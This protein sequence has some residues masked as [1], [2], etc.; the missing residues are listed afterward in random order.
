M[1]SLSRVGLLIV[2]AIIQ[3]LAPAI[4][5]PPDQPITV[6]PKV[7][8]GPLEPRVQQAP[9]QLRGDANHALG[10]RLI[11]LQNLSAKAA[12]TMIA[13]DPV[14]PTKIGFGRDVPS[15]K[16]QQDTTTQ[17]DWKPTAGGMIGSLAINSNG[18][19][20]LR[21]GI[22]IQSIPD[23]AEVRFFSDNATEVQLVSG[24][25]IMDLIKQN[26][27][28]S[29]PEEA[30]RVY[31]SP[32]IQGEI[33]GVEVFIPD[34]VKPDEVQIS[35]PQVSHLTVSPQSGVLHPK[36]IGSS[37]S[38]EQDAICSSVWT[39]TSNAVAQMV[40]MNNGSPYIC[41]G[42]LLN[43][44]A[45]DGIPYFLT[46]NHCISTQSI[47]STLQTYWFWYSTACNSGVL[48]P[49]NQTI[50]VGA[51]L[52]YSTNVTDTSFLRLSS[53]P[54]L[55]VSYAGWSATTPSIGNSVTGLHNPQGDLRKISLGSLSSFFTCIDSGVNSFNCSATDAVS[56]NYL[57]VL[58]TLGITEGGSSGSSVFDASSK[59]VIGQ[60][61]G[62]TLN[63]TNPTGYAAYGRFDKAYSNGNLGQWLNVQ[64]TSYS[65]NISPNG[66]DFGNVN[67]GSTST[68]TVSIINNSSGTVTF[69]SGYPKIINFNSPSQFSIKSSSCGASLSAGASCSVT[70]AFSPVVS[71][72]VQS[73]LYANV[74][75]IASNIL[76]SFP[77]TGVGS[78][79]LNTLSITTSSNGTVSS[80]PAG[81]NCGTTCSASFT[82]GTSVTL[83]ATPNSG[84]TFSGWSGACS[85][86]GACTVTMNTAQ[87]V[88][89]NFS[90]AA[91][92]TYLLSILSAFNGNVTSSPSG[93][94]CGLTCNYSFPAGTG[95]LLTAT[96]NAGYTFTG[97]SGAC[98]GNGA[99]LLTMNAIQSVSATFSQSLPSIYLISVINS[100]N[101][102]VSSNS[103]KIDC[104]FVCSASYSSGA[105]EV[106]FANPSPGYTFT[107]WSGACSGT[108]SCILTVSS[109]Q[110][111][112]ANFVAQTPTGKTL[113]VVVPTD[114]SLSP[115]GGTIVSTP[116]GINCN[117][118]GKPSC[119][120]Q[121]PLGTQ[122][123][124]TAT[125]DSGSHIQFWDNAC[126]GVAKGTSACTVIMDKDKTASVGFNNRYLIVIPNET[127]G[128]GASVSPTPIA[129]NP[130]FSTGQ[131]YVYNPDTIVTL[132][133]KPYAGY[134][135]SAWGG[136][137]C[138][139][140]GPCQLTMNADYNLTMT[141]TKLPTL[142]VTKSG[143]GKISSSPSGIDCGSACSAPFN[144]GAS[145]TLTANP[146]T[147]Y[148]FA[149]WS[150]ACSGTGACTVTMNSNQSVSAN[151][152]A[153]VVPTT[154]SLGVTKVGNGTITS[155]PSGIN[156]GSTCSFAYT[157]GSSVSLA[158]TPDSGYTFSGWSG[159]CTGTAACNVT[160]S[161]AQTVAATFTA[162]P[163]VFSKI[164]V[165]RPTLGVIASDVAK[166]NCG[167]KAVAC[168]NSLQQ[169]TVITL[170]AAPKAGYYTKGWSGCTSSTGDSC[171]LTIGG[172][173]MGVSAT[174]APTP[175][176]NLRVTKNK[177]G[178]VTSDPAGINC[179]ANVTS[180][181]TKIFSGTK[182]TLTA[183]P[184]AGR[185]FVGWTGACSGKDVCSLTMDGSKGVNATFQ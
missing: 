133:P 63:C 163:N 16:A 159:A 132:T 156:C 50:P 138:S 124:L 6:E 171:V 98:T 180:C 95:V 122:V 82:S 75:E 38:C 61:R 28:A 62:G 176:F 40:Y 57:Q 65:V 69:Q 129:F 24:K 56:G 146:D 144:S 66:A 142:T 93:I 78:P 25:T 85:G 71:G 100:G 37:A 67:T 140:S 72:L 157:Q 125:P 145:V 114:G 127:I 128:G 12:K 164:T 126:V 10:N 102:T 81:I 110:S 147:G 60:L 31:W 35:I 20:A 153:A 3:L 83:T 116:S 120:A 64:Q 30:A 148:T 173:P 14:G 19:A 68:N 45:G 27:A 29:D 111:V 184:I 182:V 22:R 46:A 13:Q 59:Y 36:D 8:T 166:I 161:A 42:T 53:S 109:N 91:P 108:G 107:G 185:T 155:T 43:D 113:T 51:T 160:M 141:F 175:K 4:A 151:F 119:S 137:G 18:A 7:Y 21:V 88:S 89:A 165:T 139:G 152:S 94:N 170:T 90:S 117:Q 178:S 17:L 70:V 73:F 103:G 58:Y 44:K 131:T 41:T 174:F 183:T 121:F 167:I 1:N 104:G 154:Y 34:G 84:Y 115:P 172:A 123:V 162:L 96:P 112:T 74:N 105:T 168:S 39:P 134:I 48:N 54:P 26:L 76:A 143:N 169:G 87:S 5:A 101:G 52:L 150:G 97:W 15:L 158:A 130:P 80:S 32:V 135:F 106:L 181:S 23:S 49:G 9:E 92:S 136:G 179:K 99:C 47:A 55:G 177:L 79:V 77:G 149:G 11:R 86:T 2:I 118:S 33:A